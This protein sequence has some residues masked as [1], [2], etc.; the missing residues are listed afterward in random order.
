MALLYAL[1][2]V[3]LWGFSGGARVAKFF[4][5]MVLMRKKSEDI[6]LPLSPLERL[7]DILGSSSSSFNNSPG[8]ETRLF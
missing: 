6:R 7:A 4:R 2:L 8:N 5:P 3:G 1:F